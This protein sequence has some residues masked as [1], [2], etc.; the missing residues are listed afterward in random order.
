MAAQ[1]VDA[2]D[3]QELEPLDRRQDDLREAHDDEHQ[4]QHAVEVGAV[5]P[6]AV[7]RHQLEEDLGGCAEGEGGGGGQG[8]PVGGG[9]H[10]AVPAAGGWQLAVGVPC[11]LSRTKK[12]KRALSKRPAV[13]AP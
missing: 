11:A 6:A 9:W 10:R 2:Q 12:N 13:P 7:L 8:L 4:V 1:L 5:M 3:P